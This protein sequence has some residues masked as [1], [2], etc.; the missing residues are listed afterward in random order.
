[1]LIRHS[2]YSAILQKYAPTDCFFGD[3]THWEVPLSGSVLYKYNIRERI[4]NK[5]YM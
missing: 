2:K 1:M 4:D 5:S 3:F